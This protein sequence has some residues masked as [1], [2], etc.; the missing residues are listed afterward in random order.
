[1]GDIILYDSLTFNYSEDFI[2]YNEVDD[3]ERWCMIQLNDKNEIID[4]FDKPKEQP[5]TNKNV[6]GIYNF[7]VVKQLK[8]IYNLYDIKHFIDS[9]K[10]LEFSFFLNEYINSN[11]VKGIYNDNYLDFGVL[12]DLNKSKLKVVR[13]F[14]K[15]ELIDDGLNEL[16]IR[17][18]SIKNPKKI[19]NEFLWYQRIPS[20]IRKYTPI[21]YEFN[22]KIEHD[23]GA[24]YVMSYIDSTPLQ[25]LFMY[26]LPDFNN[27]IL[28]FDNIY[29]YF[30]DTRN[31]EN[32]EQFYKENKNKLIK[33]NIKMLKEK[34]KQRVD[35]I[36]D[37]FPHKEYVIN[38]Q[39]YDNPIYHLD[40]ILKRAE[41][42]S[43]NVNI[44]NLVVLH[45]DLF[46]GNMMYNI[47]EENLKI[48]DPR[49]EY[50]EFKIYGDIRYDLAKLYHSIIGNYDF[51]VNGLYELRDYDSTLNYSIFN[52]NDN[53][54]II[55]LMFDLIEDL[56]NDIDDIEFIT[57]LL[58]LTMIPLHSENKNNQKMQF[59]KACE[60]LKNIINEDD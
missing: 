11:I 56:N 26:N 23:E 41:E 4:F 36:R 5:P 44:D 51:I 7:S 38:G 3:Y 53:S 52:G 20:Q 60:I 45:G 10:E 34:T 22:S 12:S 19:L 39:F 21:T 35:K 48:I 24:N 18:S 54:K 2:V 27:W 42:I 47:E 8:N 31:I 28:I 50:G 59:I 57:G 58:F 40:K 33:A 13:E 6:I 49:G 32:K 29:K 17:K 46:F 15:I 16:K 25:E 30:L 9:N 55:D 37:M 14:N 43:S 1:M